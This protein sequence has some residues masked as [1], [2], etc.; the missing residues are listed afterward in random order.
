MAHDPLFHVASWLT[1][2]AIPSKANDDVDPL[3]AMLAERGRL[4]ELARQADKAALD[5]E[6][7]LPEDIRKGRVQVS[8]S[9]EQGWCRLLQHSGFASEA[10]LHRWV[11]VHRRLATVVTRG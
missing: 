11:A 2:E 1:S 5:I 10:D 6:R 3:P 4:C 9:G 8:F 7:G